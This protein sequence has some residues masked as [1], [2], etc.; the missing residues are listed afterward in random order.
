MVKC[1]NTQ[2]STS[3]FGRLVRC[4][5]HGCSFARLGS[6]LQLGIHDSCAQCVYVHTFTTIKR[7][8]LTS[9]LD[10]L[11]AM[12]VSSSE[13]PLYTAVVEQ[14]GTG[15]GT[16][17]DH[18]NV[19]VKLHLQSLPT[20]LS[21]IHANIHI[22]CLFSIPSHCH[23]PHTHTHTHTSPSIH[24]ANELLSLPASVPQTSACTVSATTVCIGR[25]NDRAFWENCTVPLSTIQLLPCDG[26][27]WLAV[28]LQLV[29]FAV[30]RQSWGSDHLTVTST[31]PS[32]TLK[33]LSVGGR[34]EG[35]GGTST[36]GNQHL[37]RITT[38][39]TRDSV[40][41]SCGFCRSNNVSDHCPHHFFNFMT[42][43]FV[44]VAKYYEL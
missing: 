19:N 33:S 32:S 8:K 6:G 23:T 5:T 2:K 16:V 26:S 43:N 36:G 10:Q 42:K 44:H 41:T 40:A 15:S 25:M 18:V 35:A 11:T 24:S 29:M 17:G 4:S 31:D 27:V 1:R 38:Q 30:C 22:L 3:L 39:D 20:P 7:S 28:I 34:N 13:E 9:A 21:H 37:K 14:C 12:L